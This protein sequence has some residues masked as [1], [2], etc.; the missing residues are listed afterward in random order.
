MA[1][2]IMLEEFSGLISTHGVSQIYPLVMIVALRPLGLLFGFIAFGWAMRS[3]LML[4]ISIA[5]ALSLP[6]A[7][8]NFD[9]IAALVQSPDILT[10]APISLKEFALGYALGFLSSLPFFALQYA[11]AITDAFRGENDTGIQDPA[12]GSLHTFSIAYLIVGFFSF[13]SFGGFEAMMRSF[14]GTYQIWPIIAGF[15]VLTS[16]AWLMAA[17][18]MTQTLWSAFT[19]ALPLLSMLLLIELS[20]AIAARFAKRFN[21]HDLAFPVKNLVT[22][23]SL[24]LTMWVVWSLME[25]REA[26]SAE[27]LRLLERLLQ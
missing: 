12:G 15:P 2:R 21:F 7:A 16:S 3:G 18:L 22:V 8:G 25:G 19:I 14:Y 10:L 5:I 9:Q 26:E 17:D 24:P 27:A 4:R 11:G 23:L 6:T 20:F 1:A 13:F